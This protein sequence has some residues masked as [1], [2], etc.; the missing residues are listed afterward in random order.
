MLDRRMEPVGSHNFLGLELRNPIVDRSNKWAE[1]LGQSGRV[2][3]MHANGTVSIDSILSSYPVQKLIAR[4]RGCNLFE[5]R[6]IFCMG[7][8]S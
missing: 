8:C 1:E 3:F 7:Q 5:S 6:E 2:K 4:R